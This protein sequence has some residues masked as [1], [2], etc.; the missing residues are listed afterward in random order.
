MCWLTAVAASAILAGMIGSH[1]LNKQL[2]RQ[3]KA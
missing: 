3:I 1:I 2:T